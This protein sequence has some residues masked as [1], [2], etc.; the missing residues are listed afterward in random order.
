MW[1]AQVGWSIGGAP[2]GVALWNEPATVFVGCSRDHPTVCPAG[3]AAVL[4]V[5][6]SL[7]ELGVS[8]ALRGSVLAT[9]GRLPDA[10]ACF[11]GAYCMVSGPARSSF[12]TGVAAPVVL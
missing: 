4:L 5:A 2:T 6:F 11:L 9:P 3:D 8:T 10:C 1:D 7:R 12:A